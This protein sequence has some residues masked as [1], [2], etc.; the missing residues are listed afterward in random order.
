M[1]LQAE[2]S[3]CSDSARGDYRRVQLDLDA[4][5]E[6]T[7]SERSLKASSRV[8]SSRAGSSVIASSRVAS[9]RVASSRV[10]SS[11][12]V[13]SARTGRHLRHPNGTK[14]SASPS[15]RRPGR[16]NDGSRQS[17][18]RAS[19]A[20]KAGTVLPGESLPGEASTGVVPLSTAHKKTQK[21]ATG[22]SKQRPTARALPSAAAATE[23]AA[24][25]C[26]AADVT[27][28]GRPAD[29]AGGA[30]GEYGLDTESFRPKEVVVVV[31]DQEQEE[32][33]STDVGGVEMEVTKRAQ[34]LRDL[35]PAVVGSAA[36]WLSAPR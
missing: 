35:L 10:A 6:D 11:R 12:V 19:R 17:G 14:P 20:E 18:R 1:R 23:E 8:A 22:G 27:A 24:S 29:G 26:L 4:G 33:I 7:P 9:S 21:K 30:L 25:L 34:L 3:L 5:A 36:A 28:D 31:E 13:S 16:R 32:N 15:R 2:L